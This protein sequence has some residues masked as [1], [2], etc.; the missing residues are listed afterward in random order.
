VVPDVQVI[1]GRGLIEH[2]SFACADLMV[3]NVVRAS[4]IIDVLIEAGRERG[5]RTRPFDR[6]SVDLPSRH[7][8]L[9][10]KVDGP[11]NVVVLRSDE[12]SGVPSFCH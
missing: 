1:V 4:G 12:R 10:G 6:L 3:S 8:F 9:V 5:W 2:E 11:G 7:V